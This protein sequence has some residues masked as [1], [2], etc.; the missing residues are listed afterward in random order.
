NR[1]VVEN[2]ECFDDFGVIEVAG[3]T[4]TAQQVQ[5]RP[6]HALF[7]GYAPYRNPKISIATRIAYGY[8]SHNAA[9][10]SADILK[11]YFDLENK[12]DLLNG[13]AANVG[14]NSNSFTD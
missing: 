2:L 6:N 3:K 8:T 11:Y 4:G 1:M 13:S 9:D 5:T 14:N 12:D 10:V 7:V